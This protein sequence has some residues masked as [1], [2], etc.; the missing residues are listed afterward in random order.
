MT[1]QR[2]CDVDEKEYKI[3][4]RQERRVKK[5]IFLFHLTQFYFRQK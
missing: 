5:L 4:A 2:K 1:I 3:K